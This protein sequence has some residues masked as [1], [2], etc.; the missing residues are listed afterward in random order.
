VDPN[1]PL[2][3]PQQLGPVVTW[4]ASEA[5]TGVTNQ[6]FYVSGSH[7]GI[8]QQPKVINQFVTD[9]IWTQSEL[10]RAMPR[11]LQAR[12][13]HDEQVDRHAIARTL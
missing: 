11:L 12:K 10:D 7:L 6:I 1:D 3:G 9:H 8:M 5:A 2:Q 4:L 13:K